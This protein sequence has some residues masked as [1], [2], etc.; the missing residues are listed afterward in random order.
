MELE[1]ASG[2]SR[3]LPAIQ[4]HTHC[5]GVLAF[6]M[7]FPKLALHLAAGNTSNNFPDS[8]CVDQKPL[9]P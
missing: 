3:N 5:P 6:Q 7:P 4:Q 2:I 1:Q 9:R 8:L